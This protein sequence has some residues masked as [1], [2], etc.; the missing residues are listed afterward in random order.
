MEN[1]RNTIEEVTASDF[2]LSEVKNACKIARAAIAQGHIYTY[3]KR[4]NYVDDVFYEGWVLKGKATKGSYLAL[5]SEKRAIGHY[6]PTVVSPK[7]EPKTCRALV[8]LA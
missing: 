5:T 1:V 3:R 2:G 8:V 7:G 4:R 6:M